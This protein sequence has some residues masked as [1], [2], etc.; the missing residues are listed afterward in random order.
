MTTVGLWTRD[1]KKKEQG[2]MYCRKKSDRVVG[3]MET[4]RNSKIIDIFKT[5][6]RQVR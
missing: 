3:C 2:G 1:W 5:Q 6:K 4:K